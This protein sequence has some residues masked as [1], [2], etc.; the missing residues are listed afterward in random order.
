MQKKL[1]MDQIKLSAIKIILLAFM[2]KKNKN[3][4]NQIKRYYNH[5]AGFSTCTRS[6]FIVYITAFLT[7]LVVKLKP[8]LLTVVRCR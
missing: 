7:E 5:F 4:P 2:Q 8:V 3:G 6:Q 1:K